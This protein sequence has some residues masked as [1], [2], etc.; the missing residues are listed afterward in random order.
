MLLKLIVIENGVFEQN[1][2]RYN[3]V[4]NR[5]IET[6]CDKGVCKKRLVYV[7]VC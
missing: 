6:G 5:G 2:P 4:E 1:K 7:Q 3:L